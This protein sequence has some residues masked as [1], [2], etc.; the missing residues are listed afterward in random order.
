MTVRYF[1]E[2][3]YYPALE[4]VGVRKLSPHA[5][6]HTFAT[7]LAT[8]GVRTEDIE[9]LAWHEDYSMTANTYIHKDVD[10]LRRAVESMV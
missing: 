8:A 10:A 3:K 4:A 2:S 9:A 5:T 1:R 6:R 7:R